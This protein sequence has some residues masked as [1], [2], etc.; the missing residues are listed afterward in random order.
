MCP[1]S[2]FYFNFLLDPIQ[3]FSLFDPHENNLACIEFFESVPKG[4]KIQPKNAN[5]QNQ[6]STKNSE[7]VLQRTRRYIKQKSDHSTKT[8]LDSFEMRTILNIYLRSHM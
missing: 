7:K 6:K 4:Y 3:P 2:L 1:G 5:K 8:F